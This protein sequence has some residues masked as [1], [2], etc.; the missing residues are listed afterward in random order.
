MFETLKTIDTV[1][2]NLSSEAGMFINIALA[3]IMFGVALGIKVKDFKNIFFSPK[4]PLIGF[5]SQF[6]VLPAIKIISHLP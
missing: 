4:L 5:I 1:R 6:L 2:L 3:L